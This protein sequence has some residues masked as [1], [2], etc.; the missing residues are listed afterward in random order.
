MHIDVYL[1][2]ALLPLAFEAINI[3]SQ[4]PCIL[5]THFT[6]AYRV[7]DTLSLACPDPS[8]HNGAIAC[9]V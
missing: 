2:A 4:K 1:C 6:Q 9:S 3:C 8:S 5:P 7:L